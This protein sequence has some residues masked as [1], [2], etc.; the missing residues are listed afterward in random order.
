MSIIINKVHI[1]L[2]LFIFFIKRISISIYSN[3]NFLNNSKQFEYLNFNFFELFLFN[4]TIPNG[5]LLLEKIISFFSLNFNIT[6]YILNISYSLLFCV[7]LNDILKKISNKKNIRFCILIL[8][9]TCLLSYETWRVSH[10]DHINLFIISYLFWALFNFIFYNKNFNHL[11]ISL[12][13]L[14]LFYTLGFIFSFLI[15]FFLII[16][17]IRN[18]YKIEKNLYIKIFFVFALIFFVF[19]KNYITTSNFSSTSM[20]GANL[21]QRTVHAIGEDRYKKLIEYKKEIFPKWWILMTDEIMVR[22]KKINLVDARITNLAH[23]TL[24]SNFLT[25]FEEQKEII[26]KSNLFE[27]KIL[28]I[29]E[30]DDSI[31]NENPSFYSYGYEQ[32]LVSIKYQSFGKSIFLEACKIYP[33]ELLVGKVGNKGI[34][35]TI[36][37]MTSNAGMLPNYYEKKHKYSNNLLKYFNNI[38]RFVI[39]II[40]FLTPLILIKY[41]KYKEIKK[42]DFYYLVILSSL[43]TSIVT[44]S[45]VTCCENPRMLVMQ[46]FLI[47]LTCTMNLNY[48]SKNKNNQKQ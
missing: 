23:G 15:F 20:G 43:I 12:I 7:F 46:F 16:G 5:H 39:I 4:N 18:Y 1:F 38:M 29:V 44:T 11:I 24:D 36:L 37:Q 27:D 48:L 6:F 42:K 47:I 45:I 3:G 40:L 19:F 14:N 13:F 33:K 25:N 21:I 17:N 35:L 10:H 32:N 31:L 2:F 41:I 28:R 34:I 8:V 26:K 9:S 22:N 30:K